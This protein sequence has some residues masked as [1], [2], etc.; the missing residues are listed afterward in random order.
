MFRLHDAA[1]LGGFLWSSLFGACCAL[2]DFCLVVAY[3]L[4]VLGVAVVLWF[5]LRCLLV[6]RFLLCV[7]VYLGLNSVVLVCVLLLVFFAVLRWCFLVV[8]LGLLLRV[9]LIALELSLI[10]GFGL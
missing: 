4:V 3:L 2:A 7:R 1:C 9:G 6:F 8:C 5:V 10:C